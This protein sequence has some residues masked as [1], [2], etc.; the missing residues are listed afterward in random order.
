[1]PN[2]LPL[3]KDLDPQHIHLVAAIV[4]VLEAFMDYSNPAATAF[5]GLGALDNTIA[6]LKSAILRRK[7]AEWR[8][9]IRFQG[10]VSSEQ[11]C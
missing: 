10:Q 8:I 9:T 1:M 6:R 7:E 3:L 5:R 11:C 4:H 2:L